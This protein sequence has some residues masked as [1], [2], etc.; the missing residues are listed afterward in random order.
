MGMFK[1]KARVGN[2]SDPKRFFEEE[3][4]VDTGALHS[5]VPENRLEE[6]GI[7]PLHTRELV[8]ADGQRERRLLGEAS[9][10]VPE[11]KETLT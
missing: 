7:K 3:F 5:F 4:W 1:V 9:F 6:I 2:P 10:T 11:L 8:L